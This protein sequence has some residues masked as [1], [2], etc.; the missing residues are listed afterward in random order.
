MSNY[1]WNCFSI[2]KW[3]PTT[4][5]MNPIKKERKKKNKKKNKKQFLPF[6]K[7]NETL[8]HPT[9]TLLKRYKKTNKFYP[10]KI[11]KVKSKVNQ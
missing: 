8:L 5:N 1:L 3:D 6:E 11:L 4:P 7:K 9:W 2:G 10:L